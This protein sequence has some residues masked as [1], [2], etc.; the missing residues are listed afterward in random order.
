MFHNLVSFLPGPWTIIL[1]LSVTTSFPWWA[2]GLMQEDVMMWNWDSKGP[3]WI[4]S[5]FYW[6]RVQGS[7]FCVFLAIWILLFAVLSNFASLIQ[8]VYACSAFVNSMPAGPCLV[9]VFRIWIWRLDHKDRSCWD[10]GGISD[11]WVW[12]LVSNRRTLEQH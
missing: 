5:L 7:F 9:S 1:F 2:I 8:S 4:S 12:V 11:L 6:Y 10:W 3:K